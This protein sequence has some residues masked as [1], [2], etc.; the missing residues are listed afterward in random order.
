MVYRPDINGNYL[1]STDVAKIQKGM[2]QQQVAYIGH[3]NA[4]RPARNSDVVHVFRQQPA[5][6]TSPADLTLT[7]DSAGVLTDIRTNR[8]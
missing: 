3:P 2:T 8:R 7:F 5:M 6:K 4:A 1:T